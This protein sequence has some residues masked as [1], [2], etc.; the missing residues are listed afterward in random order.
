MT[1]LDIE[2]VTNLI[3]QTMNESEGY[4]ALQTFQFHFDCNSV[5]INDGRSYYVFMEDNSIVG[6][7]GLHHEIWGPPESVWLAWFAVR[8]DMRSRGVGGTLLDFVIEKA[9][10][11]GYMK[12]FIETYSTP[13]FSAARTFYRARGFSVAGGVKNYLPGGGTMVIFAKELSD[14]R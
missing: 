6:V 5:G 8:P 1:K 3:G 10:I 13:E 9:K 4:Q 7:V 2:P 14:A 11:Q 12:L